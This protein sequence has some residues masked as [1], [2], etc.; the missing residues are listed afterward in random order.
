MSFIVCF[1]LFGFNISISY[2]CKWGSFNLDKLSVLPAITC[3][4][5][6]EHW[7][8]HYTPCKNNGLCDAEDQQDAMVTQNKPDN[9]DCVVYLAL[10]DNGITSPT[11]EII[12]GIGTY[13]FQYKN[14]YSGR[15][16]TIIFNCNPVAIP[17][18]ENTVQCGEPERFLYELK[19]DT[20]IACVS[21]VLSDN[22][23]LSGGSIFVILF[24]SVLFGYFVIGYIVIWQLKNKDKGFV[25]LD[26]IPNVSFWIILP[27]L[28][29]TGCVVSYSFLAQKMG[30][31]TDGYDET[32]QLIEPEPT[33]EP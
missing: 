23:G 31:N 10:W 12:D 16:Q 26:N 2:A 11:Y 33:D 19:I 3:E 22:S 24:F 32:D 14:G 30:K 29:K 25:L 27:A 28:V 1:L 18:D 4:F 7:E 17:Y 20:Y 5:D 9:P 21:P 13:T 6:N 15:N 8:I